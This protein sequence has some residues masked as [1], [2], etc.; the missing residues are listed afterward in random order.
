M[1]VCVC[2]GV[3]V[4]VEVEVV[5]GG[6][7]DGES[8]H[9]P[10]SIGYHTR[11]HTMMQPSQKTIFH[12]ACACSVTGL[13]HCVLSSVELIV[14][15]GLLYSMC[16]RERLTSLL[17]PPETHTCVCVRISTYRSGNFLAVARDVWSWCGEKGAR[18]GFQLQLT[19]TMIKT[20]A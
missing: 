14:R 12:Q 13:R 3:Y 18:A 7:P 8:S 19:I 6:L 5:M 9:H 1:C 16:L 15:G 10:H 17:D 20:N 4:E 2:F 11:Y